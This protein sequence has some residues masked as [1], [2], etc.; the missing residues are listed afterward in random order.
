[1]EPSQMLSVRW[2]NRVGIDSVTCHA[3]EYEYEYRFT[4]Y[5]YDESGIL[6]GQNQGQPNA[7]SYPSQSDLWTD[8]HQQSLMQVDASYEPS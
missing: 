2:I 6:W 1:M 3:F 8:S 4:E 7:P 5:E